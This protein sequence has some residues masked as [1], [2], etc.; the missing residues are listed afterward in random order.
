MPVPKQRRGKAD[1]RARRANWKALPTAV[2]FCTNCGS[3]KLTHAVCTICGFYNGRI[4]SPRFAK[5][6]GFDQVQS[7]MQNGIEEHVHDENCGHDH[8]HDVAD[9]VV[10][11]E[12]KAIDANTAVVESDATDVDAKKEEDAS[13]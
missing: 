3:P 8:A 1:K 5:K 12:T 9:V 7:Q 2:T 10:D 6:S 4:V 13:E 11:V